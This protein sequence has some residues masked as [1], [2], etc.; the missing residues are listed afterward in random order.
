M[1]ILIFESKNTSNMQ[2]SGRYSFLHRKW[3]YVFGF[4]Q[5]SM[6][7]GYRTLELKMCMKRWSDILLLTINLSK[8]TKMI[9]FTWNIIIVTLYLSLHYVLSK[10]RQR[11]ISV[12]G[13]CRPIIPLERFVVFT[14]WILINHGL[15]S[16][17]CQR[18]PDT[19]NAYCVRYHS[20]YENELTWLISSLLGNEGL[21]FL[22][23]Y[24]RYETLNIFYI[25]HM[26]VVFAVIRLV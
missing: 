13:Q 9:N 20:V 17:R 7:C 4:L 18:P 26:P 24:S 22:F 25:G 11:Y 14:R 19:S 3:I 16:V 6:R 12:R 15:L 2:K 21:R 23:P 1:Q 10:R 8:S 5:W